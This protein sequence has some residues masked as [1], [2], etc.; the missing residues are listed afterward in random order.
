MHAA[1]AAMCIVA[2]CVVGPTVRCRQWSRDLSRRADTAEGQ[3]GEEE[4]EDAI[5]PLEVQRGEELLESSY[6]ELLPV[7]PAHLHRCEWG[8]QWRACGTG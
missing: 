5:E 4:H 2:D 7:R 1:A 6:A 8:R 3:E